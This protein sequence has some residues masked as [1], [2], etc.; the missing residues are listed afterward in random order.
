M[1]A[2]SPSNG[3]HE[4]AARAHGCGMVRFRQRLIRRGRIVRRLATPSLQAA[5]DST[6]AHRFSLLNGGGYFALRAGAAITGRGANL[7]LIDGPTESAADANS[8]AYRRSLHE[9]F[10]ST[11]LHAPAAPSPAKRIAVARLIPLAGGA[12]FAARGAAPRPAS[13]RCRGGR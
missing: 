3:C 9:W 8:D 13:A 2:T 7:L 4:H 12:Q 6:G 1:A 5:P 10:E 11:I